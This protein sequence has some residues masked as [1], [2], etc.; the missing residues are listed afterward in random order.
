MDDIETK[1]VKSYDNYIKD[2]SIFKDTIK[3]LPET[4]QSFAQFPTI[5]VSEVN[6]NQ[7]LSSTTTNFQEHS[8]NL[9]YKVDIYTKA[10]T[11]GNKKYQPRNVISELKLLTFDF[12]MNYGFYRATGT[13]NEYPDI[14]VSRY[15]CLF[16]TT[17]NNWNGKIR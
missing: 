6:N 12:F 7:N 13:K 14:T 4:P 3:V 16:S 15:T 17:R 1:I 2:K 5:I 11:V 9:T 10:I 8:S